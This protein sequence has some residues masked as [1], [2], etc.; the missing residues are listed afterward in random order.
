MVLKV[1]HHGSDD[2]LTLLDRDDLHPTIA[3]I[4][5]G[6]DHEYGH[7][8]ERVLAELGDKVEVYIT[9][10]GNTDGY[11]RDDSFISSEH[12]NVHENVGTIVVQTDGDCLWVI[13]NGLEQRLLGCNSEVAGF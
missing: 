10:R 4:S 7:S 6:N 5:V 11:I 12:P 8:S 3:V 2:G 9:T 1:P 13:I